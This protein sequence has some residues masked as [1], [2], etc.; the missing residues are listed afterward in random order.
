MRLATQQSMGSFEEQQAAP[1]HQHPD[2]R[3]TR[4]GR[5]LGLGGAENREKTTSKEDMMKSP[6]TDRKEAAKPLHVLG[7]FA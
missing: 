4:K 7:S 2:V 1:V 3:T 6:G 5:G